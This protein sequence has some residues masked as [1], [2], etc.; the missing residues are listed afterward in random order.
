MRLL[1]VQISLCGALLASVLA[2]APALAAD[3]PNGATIQWAQTLLDKKG[4]YNGRATGKMDGATQSA[5]AQYQKSVKLK[6]TGRL[7]QATIDRLMEGR[8]ADKTVG[9]LAD[10][11]SRAKASQPVLREEVKPEAAPAAVSVEASGS[12]AETAITGA[13][14]AGDPLPP[15][16]TLARAVP[17]A[18]LPRQNDSAMEEQPRAAERAAVE[19]TE[20]AGEFDLRSLTAPQWVRYGLLGLIALIML[21][22][23]V[24]WWSTGRRGNLR[25]RRT[26][27]A[28]P[29]DHRREPMF[30]AGASTDGKAAPVLRATPPGGKPAGGPVLGGGTTGNGLRAGRF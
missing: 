26:A 29:A 2:A 23:A 14:R 8:E 12:A 25:A 11:T 3:E 20:A 9:N 27:A 7:D 30:D 22:I 17:P 4:F 10:P 16:A 6:A 28:G 18:A 15:P 24:T 21:G 19:A 13:S 1:A 5:I